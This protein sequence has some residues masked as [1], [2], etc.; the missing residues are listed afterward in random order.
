MGKEHADHL[1]Q[2]IKKDYELTKDWTGDLYCGIQLD[3]DYNAQANAGMHQKGA[4]KIQTSRPI[5]TATLSLFPV[6]KTVQRKG[7]RNSPC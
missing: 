5:K 7:T 6:P 3:L 1:I 2:C 4:T